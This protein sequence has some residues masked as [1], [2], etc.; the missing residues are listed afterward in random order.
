MSKNVNS[1]TSKVPLHSVLLNKHSYLRSVQR[2]EMKIWWKEGRKKAG[3]GERCI[4][5]ELPKERSAVAHRHSLICHCSHQ[6]SGVATLKLSVC[7][8]VC[9]CVYVRMCV[10]WQLWLEFWSLAR[11]RLSHHGDL[12]PR[13]RE[14]TGGEREDRRMGKENRMIK[15]GKGK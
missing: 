12:E 1:Q 13:R 15:E 4:V 6:A 7:D 3:G 8:C 10:W 14:E 11:E 2:N 5:Y 9:V